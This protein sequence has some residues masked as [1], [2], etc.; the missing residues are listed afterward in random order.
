MKNTAICKKRLIYFAA[1]VL[2]TA[3]EV[4]IA[5]FVH[6][7]FIR[8]YGGDVIVVWVIYCFV[9]ALAPQKIKLLPLWVF[10]FAVLTELMQY[11]DIV[12]VLGIENRLLKTVIGSTFSFAD[13]G[14]Y[15]AGCAVLAAIECLQRKKKKTAQ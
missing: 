11:I 7:S 3:A 2:L 1:F 14:C 10:L 9:R 12:A 13:I 5:L 8:P 15:A 6:D 4:I